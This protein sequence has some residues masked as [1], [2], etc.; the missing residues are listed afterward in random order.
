MTFHL[1]TARRKKRLGYPTQKPKPCSNASSRPAATKATSSPTS[2]AAPAPRPRSPKS[3]A[4][5]GS[6]PTSASSPSTPPASGMIGVQRELKADGQEL[7]RVRNPQPRPV[8]TSG[9]P[10]RRRPTYAR[11]EGAEAARAKGSRVPRPDPARLPRRAA[12]RR[13]SLLPR[14]EGRPAGRRRPDQPAGRPPVRRGGHPRMPQ[15]QRSPAWTCSRF[16]FEMGLFPAVL[17]EAAPRA[18]TSRRSTSRPRSSTSGPSKRTRSSST[19]CASSRS[20]RLRQ[21]ATS[22]RVDRADRLLGLLLAGRGRGRRRRASRT[23]E[24]KIVCEQGQIVKVSK[25]KDGIVTRETLTKHWTDWIDYWAVDFDYESRKEIIKRPEDR[26]AL[27][28]PTS[29]GVARPGE[30]PSNSRS[31]GP[32]ATSSRTNGRAS[33]P[34]RTASSS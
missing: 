5:S 24:R 3:W 16:E 8:R 13:L 12:R 25:D 21:E 17:D 31:A 20:S 28:A 1:L 15:E 29:P 33:A 10:Q 19:T 7:P 18:S 30:R 23:Q 2:S 26:R 14:Q 9:L 11:A 27:T 22:S 32:A 34:A 6:S 4:A